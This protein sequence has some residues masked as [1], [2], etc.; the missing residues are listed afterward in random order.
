MIITTVI[1]TMSDADFI[2]WWLIESGRLAID[3]VNEEGIET[4]IALTEDIE[5]LK[6]VGTAAYNQGLEDG[7]KVA[8]E[9]CDW[10]DVNKFPSGYKAADSIG[11]AIREKK[12]KS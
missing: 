9:K 1:R 10:C 2:R 4:E 8:D 12:I 11:N 7:A 6:R 5:A 3:I